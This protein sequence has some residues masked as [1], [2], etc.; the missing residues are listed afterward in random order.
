MCP[1]DVT[2]VSIALQW[3][4]DQNVVQKLVGY[5][6]HTADPEVCLCVHICTGVQCIIL[7]Y[8]S[9]AMLQCIVGIV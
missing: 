8:C 1:D 9:V 3:L 4:N 7:Y 2:C 6:H 5:I